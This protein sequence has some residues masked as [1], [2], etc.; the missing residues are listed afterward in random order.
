MR[1]HLSWEPLVGY[2]SY[3]I[4]ALLFN[5]NT[6]L[7]YSELNPFQ[8]KAYV[9]TPAVIGSVLFTLGGYL[10]CHHNHIWKHFD[11]GSATHWLSFLNFIGGAL[12]LVAGIA[13]I[14]G[15]EEKSA[16]WLVDFTYLLGSAA[17]MF[18]GLCALWLWKSEFYG[19]GLLSEMN[20]VRRNQGE[21]EL[22]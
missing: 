19:L 3:M 16:L 12:F 21:I 2:F 11:C 20:V 13:G 7:G 8:E 15:A 10:E 1:V 9:W 14:A 17:F 18:G 22:V 5:V 4:G 6:G